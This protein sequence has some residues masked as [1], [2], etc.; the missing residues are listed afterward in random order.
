MAGILSLSFKVSPSLKA[1]SVMHPLSWLTFF[2][3]SCH[4]CLDQKLKED[5]KDEGWV[6]GALHSYASTGSA[7]FLQ[8]LPAF[9]SVLPIHLMPSAVQGG[10][11]NC[12]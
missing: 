3:S 5:A 11:L 6:S 7:I 8:H 10:L 1:V 9:S 12:L 2:R 4:D